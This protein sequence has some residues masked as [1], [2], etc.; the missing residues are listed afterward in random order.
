MVDDISKDISDID[1]IAVISEVNMMGSNPKDW[2]I[3]TS[4]TRMY[5]M[6]RRCSPPLNQ[7]RLRKRCS[8][9]ILLLHKSKTK[10]K[11]S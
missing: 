10:E 4:A 7:L 8:W 6:I 9:V 5:A 2:Y 3:D 11:W 1:L